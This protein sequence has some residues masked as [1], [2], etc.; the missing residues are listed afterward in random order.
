MSLYYGG[1][2]YQVVVMVKSILFCRSQFLFH[3][4]IMRHKNMYSYQAV[5]VN[6]CSPEGFPKH[7]IATPLRIINTE[8]HITLNLMPVYRY[9][10]LFSVDTKISTTTYV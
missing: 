5:H 7:I 10:H 6:P 8:G 4:R 3:C 2:I 9:G 1:V